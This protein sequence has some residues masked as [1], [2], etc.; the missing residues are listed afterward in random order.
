ML[1]PNGKP[2]TVRRALKPQV[3]ALF[4]MRVRDRMSDIGITDNQLAVELNLPVST[5]NGWMR[6]SCLPS[7]DRLPRLARALRI[8]QTKLLVG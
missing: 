1:G 2:R 7:G 6:G 8:N 5:V 3:F 4:G